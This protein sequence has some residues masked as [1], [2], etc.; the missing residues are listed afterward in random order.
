MVLDAFTNVGIHLDL[1]IYRIQFDLFV[2]DLVLF[3]RFFDFNIDDAHALQYLDDLVLRT[4]A[5]LHIVDFVR[6]H[7]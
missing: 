5:I 6:F 2:L 4:D 7:A 1:G 3:G